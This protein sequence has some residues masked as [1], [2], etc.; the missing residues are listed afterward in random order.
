MRTGARALNKPLLILGIDRRLAGLAFLVSV[1]VGANDGFVSKLSALVLFLA[2]WAIGRRL[3]RIDPNIFQ[4]MNHVRQRKVLY[5]PL[6]RE[7]FCLF[8]ERREQ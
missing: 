8:V 4:V 3:T 2:M 5:D 6:K 1:I 7:S